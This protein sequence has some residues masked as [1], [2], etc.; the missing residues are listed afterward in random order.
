[1]SPPHSSTRPVLDPSGTGALNPAKVAECGA[2]VEM[3]WGLMEA[4]ITSRDIMTMEA[5]GGR[6]ETFASC[7]PFAFRA[8]IFLFAMVWAD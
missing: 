1:M 4:R 3:L 2:A 8:C 5:R 7:L 6:T